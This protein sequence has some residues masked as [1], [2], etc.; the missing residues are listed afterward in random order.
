MYVIKVN[1]QQG[2]NKTLVFVWWWIMFACELPQ[3]NKSL[4]DVLPTQT[5]QEKKKIEIMKR[6]KW[7]RKM[8]EIYNWIYECHSI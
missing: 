3:N 2:S 1:V 7:E 6:K 4:F 8:I 5:K